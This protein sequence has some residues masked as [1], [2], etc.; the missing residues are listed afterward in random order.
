MGYEQRNKAVV[1]TFQNLLDIAVQEYGDPGAIFSLID[2][3]PSKNFTLDSSLTDLV[4]TDIFA[5]NQTAT[6]DALVTRFELDSRVVVN[7][8]DD[9][10]ADLRA[11]SKGFS[12]GFS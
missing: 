10:V 5:D 2:A 9:T 4:T 6:Q 1:H 3:N 8:D 12:L 7:G 11:F